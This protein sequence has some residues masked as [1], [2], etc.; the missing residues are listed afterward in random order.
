M[1]RIEKRRRRMKRLRQA[2]GVAD[3]G[4]NADVGAELS[5]RRRS[6]RKERVVDDE[7][8]APRDGSWSPVFGSDHHHG[9]RHRKKKE[10]RRRRRRKR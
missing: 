4:D 5:N 9:K 8:A 1:R 10:E 7:R 6:R 2:D 3:D